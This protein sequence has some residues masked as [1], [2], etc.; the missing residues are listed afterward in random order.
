MNLSDRIL[1]LIIFSIAGAGL[2][3][4]IIVHSFAAY[5]A[6]AS[7]KLA[8]A[9][10]ASQPIALLNLANARLTLLEAEALPTRGGLDNKADL[11]RPPEP[12]AHRSVMD[13]NAE[14]SGAGRDWSDGTPNAAIRAELRALAEL[15]LSTAP[16]ESAALFLLGQIAEWESDHD[17]AR[18]LMEAAVHRSI[19]ETSAVYQLMIWSLESR[20]YADAIDRADAIMRTA[21]RHTR[22]IGSLL[23]R[24]VENE[25]GRHLIERRLAENPPWRTA[26][27]S[28]ML[29]SVSDA[30]AP[31]HILLSLKATPAP[32]TTAELGRYLSFLIRHKLYELAY[33]VWLQFL[34]P[35]DLGST[36][37]LYNGRFER[38]LSGL[39]FDWH[40]SRGTGVTIQV[41]PD[42][43]LERGRALLIEFGQGR[44]EFGRVSQL[45]LLSPGTYRLT[46]RIKGE[47][48]GRRGL[49]WR[50]SCAGERQVLGAS[51]MMVGLAPM[52]RTFGFTFEVPADRPCRAQ[53]VTL[54]L[55]ARS[56]SE[57]LVSG[58]IRYADLTIERL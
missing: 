50:V 56:T 38:P 12:A 9:L 27:L 20:N 43:S 44:V 5:F 48:A 39:P 13:Q 2:L 3:W 10:N 11:E 4:L 40:I 18:R 53:T 31:F 55:D 51:E 28:G 17:R 33:Y 6:Q 24:V 26:F 23:A 14:P 22:H 41:S 47:L 45:I 52:W 34:T 16:L 57:R 29:R 46:G 35:E 8:L 1:R 32:P 7:P 58:I 36:G 19:R 15:I 30:R 49:V 54:T 37:L 25:T 42:P 21:P